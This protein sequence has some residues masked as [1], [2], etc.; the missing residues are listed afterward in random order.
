MKAHQRPYMVLEVTWKTAG[1][2]YY[3]DRPS[4]SFEASGTRIPTVEASMVVDWGSLGQT[5]REDQVG[6]VDALTVKLE[7]HEGEITEILEDDLQ[8][9]VAVR[10][11]RMFD[12][13]DVVWP[14]DRAIVFVGTTKP[15]KYSEA[16][17]TIDLPIEDPARRLA[18]KA[19]WLATEEIFPNVPADY[20]D[21]QIPHAWGG[22]VKRVEAVCVDGPWSTTILGRS[23]GIALPGT[24]YD[25]D[26]HP[27]ELHIRTDIDIL[28]FI[29]TNRVT[30]RFFQSTDKA[31]K[32]SRMKIVSLDFVQK[33]TSSVAAVSGQGTIR[34]T[35]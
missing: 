15:Q 32:P 13:T 25:I 4:N 17:N 30:A 31:L 7:D 27:D 20:R 34:R 35:I 29:G 19:E 18:G 11:F 22:I 16:Q 14:D 23:S 8:Q 5:L 24:F 9:Y 6:S 26:D 3:I 12:E 10:V 2:K 33:V 21:K 28:V 1:V